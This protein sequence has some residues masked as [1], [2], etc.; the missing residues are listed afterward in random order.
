MRVST[1][2][3]EL[4]GYSPEFQKEQLLEQVK[5]KDYKGWVTKPDWHF[6]EQASG[7]QIEGRKQL[8]KLIDLVKK[9]DI[10]LVLVWKIDRLSRNL[11]DL[12][13]LFEEFDKYS[14]GFA[15]MKEDLDFT[16]AIGKLIFQI[17][18]ALA[19]F[20]RE[21]IKMRTEEGR[22]ASALAGNYTA[23]TIPYGYANI[24]NPSGKGKKLALIPEEAKIV[25]RVFEWFIQGDKNAAWIAGEL[26]RLGIPKGQANTRVQGTK[27]REFTIRSMLGSEEY[28]G[29]H[30]TN[31]YYLV[32]K[33]PRRHAVRPKE[34]WI[35]SRV[36]PVVDDMLFYMSQEKLKRTSAKPAKGGGKEK[37]MLRGKLVEVTTK[38]G[39]VG[40]I[41]T[42]GT[43]NYRRKQYMEDGVQIPSI[44]IAAKPL[45]DFVWGYIE[46]AIDRPEEFLKIHR[47]R[48]SKN[49]EKDQLVNQLHF[50]EDALSDV[51]KKIEKVNEDFYSERISDAQRQDWLEKYTDQQEAAVKGKQKAEQDL[52]RLGQ[53]DLACTHLREFAA[54]FQKDMNKGFT[55]EQKQKFVDMLVER[56]EISDTEEGRTANV[57]LRFDPKEISASIPQVEPTLLKTKPKSAMSGVKNELHGA[58]DGN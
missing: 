35:T 23:G 5:R 43:K 58:S 56:I 6:Y 54:K 15:S 41:A 47:R 28:R 26:D 34:E 48:M 3:Q 14:V 52:A 22:R 13:F 57:L 53:Y 51:N 25:R 44:S 30:I 16:G 27:W 29:I 55:Y 42:K 31:R 10:D 36:P 38:R 7:S 45:E 46:K 37:Y 2:E 12:L 20:E 21:N 32:S 9:G 33:K 40:Y 8:Q 4:E 49:N 24:P 50:Y 1:A 39:F 19:E 11:S 18:G 17:F